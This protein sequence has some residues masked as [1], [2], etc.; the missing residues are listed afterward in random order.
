LSPFLEDRIL[1]KLCVVLLTSLLAACSSSDN[2][3]TNAFRTL[4]TQFSDVAHL[5]AQL[6]SDQVKPVSLNNLSF[7]IASLDSNNKIDITA[8]SPVINFPEG[9]SFVAA[10]FLPESINRFTFVLE[11]KA[12][13]TVFV[14]S[15]VFLNENNQQIARIDNAQFNAKGFFSIERT[16]TAESAQAIR[17]ILVYSK[18]SDLDGRSELVDPAREYELSKG[19]ELSEQSFPKL[20]TKHSPIGHLNIQFKDVFF[21]AQ[22][23]NNQGTKQNK[24]TMVKSAPLVKPPTILSDTEVFYLQQIS[25]AIKEGNGLRAKSLVEEAERAGSTKAKSHYI[26]EL[27]KQL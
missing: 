18:N 16:F 23:I 1:K 7:Q 25:K 10:L 17:Y 14:P 11:S 27:D 8:S 24:V 12:G 26:Q 20:Y 5:S 6:R 9:N 13:R 15:V 21:S 3:V 4:D 2:I 22:A 19:R